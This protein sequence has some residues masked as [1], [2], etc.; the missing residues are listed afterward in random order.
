MHRSVHFRAYACYHLKHAQPH[1]HWHRNP[2]TKLVV[3]LNAGF[4]SGALRKCLWCTNEIFY[5]VHVYK[6]FFADELVNH[7]GDVSC[8][9]VIKWAR[10]SLAEKKGW[11]TTGCITTTRPANVQHSPDFV[12]AFILRLQQFLLLKNIYVTL[13]KCL[14][15]GL[16]MC[17]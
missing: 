12:I 9:P 7:W 10:T 2:L 3:K 6:P 11:Q 14:N 16:L 4:F 1:R 8:V 5:S 17:G 15:K 13:R